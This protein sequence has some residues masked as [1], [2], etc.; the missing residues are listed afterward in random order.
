MIIKRLRSAVPFMMFMSTFLF[1]RCLLCEIFYP[2][3]IGWWLSTILFFIVGN[4]LTAGG[5]FTYYLLRNNCNACRT[6]WSKIK[7]EEMV[8][9][10]SSL[11]LVNLDVKYNKVLNTYQC[12]NCS[13]MS[14]T[15][16]KK[17]VLV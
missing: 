5:I 14:N 7:L 2:M 10:S 11:R 3:S 8:V 6:P 12:N 13:T 9:D 17:I 16:S 15:V 1:E 4:I